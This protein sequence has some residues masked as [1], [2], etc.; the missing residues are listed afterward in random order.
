[1]TIEGEG[2]GNS[3]N[4]GDEDINIQ[5]REGVMESVSVEERQLTNT[6][7]IFSHPRWNPIPWVASVFSETPTDGCLRGGEPFT[8]RHP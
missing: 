1:M 5:F 2:G 6:R 7:A 3:G 4:H 8:T